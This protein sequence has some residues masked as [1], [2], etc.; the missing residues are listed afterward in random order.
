MEFISETRLCEINI[1]YIYAWNVQ[2]IENSVND[3]GGII[4]DYHPALT[5]IRRVHISRAYGQLRVNR[6]ARTL[7]SPVVLNRYINLFFKF[8]SNFRV[9]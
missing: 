9:I 1:I 2:K 5:G 3:A 6:I 8:G 7:S 4:V